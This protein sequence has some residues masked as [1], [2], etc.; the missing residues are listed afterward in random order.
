MKPSRIFKTVAFAGVVL[1]SGLSGQSLA[2]A[3]ELADRPLYLQ[4]SKVPPA[5]IMAVD[6]SGSM[7]FQ[8][9]FPGYDGTILWDRDSSSQPYS[10]FRSSGSNK[11][12]L[13]V[14]ASTRRFLHT[15]PYP[16]VRF[17][18]TAANDYLA[19]PPLDQFGF[20]R[21]HVYNP[22]YFNP[23]VTYLRWRNADGSFWAHANPEATRTNIADSGNTNTI[24]LTVD[25]AIATTGSNTDLRFSVRT[26][27]VLPKGMRYRLYDTG[28]RCGL[29]N[30]GT[31]W[32]TLGSDS[33]ASANCSLYIRYFP[34]T[35]Y[36]PKDDPAPTGYRTNDDDTY[37]P[38]IE[39]ACTYRT[40][41]G[42]DRCDMRR[43]EIKPDNYTSAAAYN[44]AIQNFANWYAYYGNRT[45]AV[46]AAMTNAMYDVD[47][48]RVGFFTI[49]NRPSGT[50]LV[51]HDM[52]VAAD[53]TA[54]FNSFFKLGAT[55]NT[56]NLPAVKAMGDQFK[57]KDDNA[58]TRLACQVNAGMLFT[59]GFANVAQ[60][61]S[62]P[63]NM[64][65]PFHEVKANSM[66]AIAA[67]YY[68]K[69][70]RP[71]FSKQDLV[72][73][74]AGCSDSGA[75]NNPRLDCKAFPHMNL[76]GITLGS[77][78]DFIGTTY[79]VT[80]SGKI[81]SDLALTQAIANPPA[82]PGFKSSTRSTVDDLWHA[83]IVSRGRFIN[84]SSPD[85]IRDAMTQILN[86]VVDRASVSGGTA[87][88]GTRREDG[89]LAYVPHFDTAT[90]S[91]N[92]KA[93]TLTP[94][95]GLG[96]VQW[97]AAARLATKSIADRKVYFINDAGSLAE[98]KAGA[99]LP[100][101]TAAAL[102]RVVADLCN[103]T[104]GHVCTRD[105]VIE[106]LR[107]DHSK[108][109]RNGGPFRDRDSRIGDILGSQPEVLSKA[110]FGYTGLA[111]A[112]GGNTYDA[113]LTSKQSRVPQIFVGSNNGMLHAFNAT[114]GE[115]N[116][117]L[118]PN[119]VLTDNMNADGTPAAKQSTFADLARP[120]YEHRYFVDGSPRQGDAYVGGGWKTLLAVPMGAGARSVVVLDVTSGASA[121]APTVLR[122]IKHND[123][124]YGVDRPRIAPL[125]NNKWA[126]V[127]GNGYNS[128][129]N[130]SKLIVQHLDSTT[131]VV[132]NAGTGTAGDPNGMA[133]GVAIADDDFDGLGDAVYA[134][135]YKGSVWKFPISDSGFTN[136][137]TALFTA[138]NPSG[139]VQRV[140]GGIDV[141]SHHQMGQIIYFGT[142][143]YLLDADRA[144]LESPPIDS[145]YGVW[146]EGWS[147]PGV[148]TAPTTTLTRSS[149]TAQTLSAGTASGG[150]TVRT[151]SSNLVNWGA[152]KG[153]RLDLAAGGTAQGERFVGVPNVALGRVIFTTFMP[154]S[155][156]DECAASGINF[157]NVVDATTGAGILTH[158]TNTGVGSIRLPDTA[159]GGGP[160]AT[161]PVVVTPPAEPCD[162]SDPNCAPPAP[163]P[164]DEDDPT[165]NPVGA[166][167]CVANLGILL[168]DGLLNFAELTCGRQSWRQVQ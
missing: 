161:P 26:G 48:M 104:T 168:S 67:E 132:V 130:A 142:G 72:P 90:W 146:D 78:G 140:T 75:E 86:A 60:T 138:T 16:G 74:S 44:A 20:S 125:K 37:R 150:A 22:A 63:A 52:N 10:F 141:I 53:K 128:N 13:R 3:I 124:G 112:M 27:M 162:P 41:T 24:N 91:G 149:L 70:L 106:Y 8:T 88:S 148:A 57:R 5:F 49:N 151:I 113:F 155:D 33:T 19:I 131:P 46:I 165:V 69:S 14:D 153:W 51:M 45:R 77:F 87:A 79:G 152:S 15:A 12:K 110:S 54:L 9:L 65:A 64:G 39:N 99:N 111:N 29:S 11:G 154:N 66:A 97:D 108:E 18:Q 71:D 25:Q 47:T 93:H 118:I 83:T 136:A 158:G 28:T 167:E 50:G 32:T 30:T 6:D 157:I 84:A 119:S 121:T 36:L 1:L 85:E 35:F 62:A 163:D 114:T 135:D 21:S 101:R 95:G 82:W 96:A 120:D 139:G 58:P 81:D 164:D 144:V 76:H 94:T 166:P 34:A 137:S 103:D 98:F 143:R 4:Q 109:A 2:A 123:I 126:V 133:G 156:S 23:G 80:E 89:F 56:P 145:F 122:E 31:S 38:I 100:Q 116:W 43:Y 134:G 105:D 61:M 102:D 42:S 115:E 7:K 92:L 159:S 160:V 17:T 129:N 59:D 117:A 147:A 68:L 55:G 107:G 127:F 73:V 40:A